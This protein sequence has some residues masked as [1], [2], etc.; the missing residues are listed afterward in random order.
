MKMKD[1]SLLAFLALGVT[2]AKYETANIKQINL[3]QALEKAHKGSY[4]YIVVHRAGSESQDISRQNPALALYELNRIKNP[5]TIIFLNGYRG[6]TV[7]EVFEDQWLA[8]ADRRKKFPEDKYLEVVDVAINTAANA[9][10]LRKRKYQEKTKILALTNKNHQARLAQTL[11]YY[12]TEN[13]PEKIDVLGVQGPSDTFGN[14]IYEC[15][16]RLLTT[17][18]FRGVKKGDDP[19]KLTQIYNQRHYNPITNFIKS[20]T[21]SLHPSQKE[22]LK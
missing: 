2:C 9:G 20:I 7:D 17:Y 4:E 16:S 13:M 11:G 8:S 3:E 5:G 18:F 15:F 1:L 21:G 12:F 10:N 14:K 6:K 19:D 22:N